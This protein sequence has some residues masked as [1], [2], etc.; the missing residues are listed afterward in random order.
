MGHTHTHTRTHTDTPLFNSL[1]LL[2]ACIYTASS[3]LLGSFFPAMDE[4][5]G[6]LPFE[7][8]TSRRGSWQGSYQVRG[9]AHPPT[10]HTSASAAAA[11]AAVSN[12]I[13]PSDAYSCILK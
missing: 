5:C 2:F 1:I 10:V 13:N 9:N 4:S 6:S 12:I 3:T 8:D 7:S 11:A